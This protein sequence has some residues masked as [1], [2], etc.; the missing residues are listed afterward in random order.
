MTEEV[1]WNGEDITHLVDVQRNEYYEIVKYEVKFGY[2]V[3]KGEPDI[4]IDDNKPII[5]KVLDMS[6][7]PDYFTDV[8]RTYMVDVKFLNHSLD[9]LYD[10]NKKSWADH[11]EYGN[12]EIFTLTE[13]G[14]QE[15]MLFKKTDPMNQLVMQDL[16]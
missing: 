16:F 13:Y 1:K 5:I 10:E 4:Y 6:F 11:I 2:K 14:E 8:D 7:D 12:D 9:E 15:T 3:L